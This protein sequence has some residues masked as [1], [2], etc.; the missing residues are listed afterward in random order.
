[1]SDEGQAAESTVDDTDTENRTTDE[2][3]EAVLDAEAV[4]AAETTDE[5]REV[6]DEQQERIEELEDLLLD[7]ST[8]VADGNSMGV[9]PDCH[10]AVIKVDPWFRSAKIKC[11]EC[12][13]VFHEY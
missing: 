12:E 10:G 11:T 8:R 3:T 1:M 9:C 6:V 13:R 4:E 7:L 2:Q 5:L